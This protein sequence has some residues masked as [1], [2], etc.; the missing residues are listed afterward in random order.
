MNN[1]EENK[2]ESI[3][4]LIKDTDMFLGTD[5]NRLASH[6]E[7]HRYFLG[8][9]LKSNITWDEATFS[10]M[11]NYYQPISQVMENWTTQM[12]FPGR[13]RADVFFEICDHLY[14]LSI[15]K[16]REVNV[17]EAVLS[18]DANFGKA[19]GRFMARLLFQSRV[20]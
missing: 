7:G 20:A 1:N 17:Y 4:F 2:K 16:G 13:R 12:S 6:I 19:L 15:E 11:S 9:N 5:Y 10:W 14:Y 3:E 18:Y 8:K